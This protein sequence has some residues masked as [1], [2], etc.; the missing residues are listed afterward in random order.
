MKRLLLSLLALISFPAWAQT[1]SITIN[2]T[3]VNQGTAAQCLY[4]NSSNRVGQQACG[5]GT[6]QD[7]QVG[8]TTITSGTTLRLLYDNAGVLG[9]SL[10]TT[11][12]AG[13]INIP[14]AQTMQIGGANMVADV[15]T[16]NSQFYGAAIPAL[17]SS[18][19]GG[20]VECAGVYGQYNIGIGRGAMPAMTNGCWNIAIG[21]DALK[22]ANHTET[23]SIAIGYQAL[24]NSESLGENT[25]VGWRSMIAST[26]G[27]HNVA[28]GTVSLTTNTTGS[29]NTSIGSHSSFLGLT[30]AENTSVGYS[31]LRD[32]STTGHNTGIGANAGRGQTGADN[33]S[34]G[35]YAFYHSAGPGTGTRNTVV[36]SLAAQNST[37]SDITVIGYEAQNAASAGNQ[38][39]LIGSLAG[40]V[41]TAAGTTAVGYQAL[42]GN[43]SSIGNVAIGQ[44][45]LRTSTGAGNTAVG[46]DAGRGA[47]L[48]ATGLTIMGYQAGFSATGAANYNSLFGYASGTGI[49]SGVG[50]T[51]LGASSISAS[52]NQITTGSNN[53]AI[54]TNVAVATDTAS[55]QL[56]IGNF[57]YGTGLSGTGATISTGKIGFGVKAPATEIDLLG[58]MTA[59]GSYTSGA[60]NTGT[61]AAWK[62]GVSVSAACVLDATRYIQLDVAG[63]LVKVATC[64]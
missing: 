17:S 20:N 52:Y 55:N 50:N 35:A 13:T 43:I 57:I 63:T 7:I 45:A 4:V 19:S 21:T 27:I 64:Q 38:V 9:E 6:A 8:V 22:T 40:F 48:T 56:V 58:S 29:W 47:S 16:F 51:L 10:T 49:T 33:T 34:V 3:P 61:A 5:T 12:A 60:P 14:A 25:A 26:T 23:L 39:T 41:N 15:T 36:G 42:S 32:V 24:M 44:N 18:S 1:N 28:M 46:V 2:Q 59:S 54:G 62:F 53:I 31:A 11:T 30:G 37:A